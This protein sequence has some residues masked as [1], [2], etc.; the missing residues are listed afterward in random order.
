MVSG[1]LQCLGSSQHLK[2]KYGVYYEFEIRRS[3]FI[4]NIDCFHEIQRVFESAE[5]DE[6]HGS[7]F[8]VKTSN[9]I[10]LAAA[11]ATL[12]KMKSN[13]QIMNYSIS[14]STLEQIFIKFAARQEEEKNTRSHDIQV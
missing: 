12:E 5:L 3:K 11:F 8:R 4:E 6:E 13:S 9:D 14:Q 7:F 10:D 1:R 2:S